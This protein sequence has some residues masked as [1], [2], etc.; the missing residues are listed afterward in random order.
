MLKKKTKLNQKITEISFEK[1][2][3]V[4]NKPLFHKKIAQNM[5]YNN[6]YTH[7]KEKKIRI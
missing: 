5:Q 4:L 1:P 2:R 6:T 3:I 7:K